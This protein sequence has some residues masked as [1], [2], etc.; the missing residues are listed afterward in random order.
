MAIA[1]YKVNMAIHL[2]VR[3]A[4]FTRAV[5]RRGTSCIEQ[6]KESIFQ[7]GAFCGFPHLFYSSSTVLC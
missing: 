4:E 3:L 6:G 2:A 1:S 5:C 7:A